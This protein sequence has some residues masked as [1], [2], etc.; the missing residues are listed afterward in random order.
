[1]PRERG[2]AVEGTHLS[3]TS[4]FGH[5]KCQDVGKAPDVIEFQNSKSKRNESALP[6]EGPPRSFFVSFFKIPLLFGHSF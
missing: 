1:M 2:F 6:R 4:V 5:R 3:K